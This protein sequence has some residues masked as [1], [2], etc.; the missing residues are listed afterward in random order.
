MAKLT[1]EGFTF[2]GT[3][4]ELAELTQRLN[5]GSRQPSRS[6]VPAN[7]LPRATWRWNDEAVRTV[8]NHVWGKGEKVLRAFVDHGREIKYK[9]LCRY[10]GMRGLQLVGPLSGIRKHVQNAIGH[11][12]AKLI[13]S[14]WVVPGDRDERI[15]SIHT[16][17][18]E[19]LCR[20][21]KDSK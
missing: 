14:R 1:F 12:Y 2:E 17:A 11:H 18:W 15:Y 8:V 13:E 3:P 20:V 5:P 9:D 4:E 19:S 6:S 10:T 16:D 21:M 7:G